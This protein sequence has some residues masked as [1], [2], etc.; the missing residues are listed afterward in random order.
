ME[1][2]ARTLSHALLKVHGNRLY[3][4][5][6]QSRKKIQIRLVITVF[7]VLVIVETEILVLTELTKVVANAED[8]L[9][10]VL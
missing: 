5:A 7:V 4:Y 9:H 8:I 10:E 6:I 1:N 2:G 3:I